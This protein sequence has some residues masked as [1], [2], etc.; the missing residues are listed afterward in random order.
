MNDTSRVGELRVRRVLG[1]YR[2]GGK[3]ENP[4]KDL[5]KRS[6]TSGRSIW[7]AAIGGLDEETLQVWHQTHSGGVKAGKR[8]TIMSDFYW[9]GTNG[10]GLDQ[11]G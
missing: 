3:L 11:S 4:R 9:D 10:Q 8:R 2:D 5:E 7:I 1:R 6:A